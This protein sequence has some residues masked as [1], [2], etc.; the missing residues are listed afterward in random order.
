L[1]KHEKTWNSEEG[2]T[3]K[4]SRI[5]WDWKLAS[6]KVVESTFSKK[7][8]RNAHRLE[9]ASKKGKG[10]CPGRRQKAELLDGSQQKGE[11]R[12]FF[13]KEIER[14]SPLLVTCTGEN[15][16]GGTGT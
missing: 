13:D 1:S 3:T 15:L 14:A 11:R 7:D 4:K 10:V 12:G 8:Q 5:L 16:R 6:L 9:M 2:E